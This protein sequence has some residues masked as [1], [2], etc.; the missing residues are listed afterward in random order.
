MSSDSV[1]SRLEA[2]IAAGDDSPETW[3]VYADWLD[4]HGDPRGRLMRLDPATAEHA[5]L[6]AENWPRWFAGASTAAFSQL[7]WRNGFIDTATIRTPVEL[8]LFS[9]H[10]C[11]FV[12]ELSFTLPFGAS[13]AGLEG[14][15]LLR[16]VCVSMPWSFE[17]DELR[18]AFERL[19]SLDLQLVGGAEEGELAVLE[20][21]LQHLRHLVLDARHVPGRVFERVLAAPW[22]QHLQTLVLCGVD[23]RSASVLLSRPDSLRWL[24]RG[25]HLEIAEDEILRAELLSTLP[26]ATLSFRDQSSAFSVRE[27]FANRPFR[28]RRAW[29]LSEPRDAPANYSTYPVQ[30]T[31]V[32][33]GRFA[34]AAGVFVSSGTEMLDPLNSMAQPMSCAW[35]ASS[36][37]LVI[38]AQFDG[39]TPHG[40]ARWVREWRCEEC[41]RYSTSRFPSEGGAQR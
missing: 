15:P 26:L 27:Q 16:R 14:L 17:A 33:H 4:E 11:R 7:V 19:S 28:E 24:G 40:R 2:L 5:A 31:P 25:L 35:C 39:Q 41:G 3:A 23:A 13:L 10:V 1:V 18:S 12:R 22:L 37:T 9:L 34:E 30:L 20:W 38:F 36:R 21:Q 32:R 8:P 29:P 6:V